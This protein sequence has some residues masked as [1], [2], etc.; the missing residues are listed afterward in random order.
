VGKRRRIDSFGLTLIVLKARKWEFFFGFVFYMC[1][2][3]SFSQCLIVRHQLPG[4]PGPCILFFFP[5]VSERLCYFVEK[6]FQ[7]RYIIKDGRES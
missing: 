4:W 7:V 5:D 6:I 1:C 2:L 3:H